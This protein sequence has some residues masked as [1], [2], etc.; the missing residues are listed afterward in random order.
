[1]AMKFIRL[2][3]ILILVFL[4]NACFSSKYQTY[5][6]PPSRTE[7]LD[8]TK[9]VTGPKRIPPPDSLEVFFEVVTSD[10]ACPVKIELRD[11]M[12]RL[13]R[14]LVDSVYSPGKYNYIWEARDSLGGKLRYNRYYYKIFSC[15]RTRTIKFDYKTKIE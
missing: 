8:S 7:H 11:V 3:I 13:Q 12:T 1:M 9:A 15:G 6:A 4:M 14:I 10:T 2:A 5:T